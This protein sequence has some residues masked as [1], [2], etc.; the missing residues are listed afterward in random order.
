[1]QN[2]LKFADLNLNDTIWYGHVG[3]NILGISLL[4]FL[5]QKDNLIGIF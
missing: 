3:L 2:E 1:M 5:V 4:I